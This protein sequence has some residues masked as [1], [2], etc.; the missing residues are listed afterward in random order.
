MVNT[1]VSS[2]SDLMRS[3]IRLFTF[4]ISFSSVVTICLPICEIIV[5]TGDLSMVSLFSS[6]RTWKLHLYLTN[7]WRKRNSSRS[8]SSDSLRGLYITAL[9]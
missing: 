1:S 8:C 5:L 4:S 7:V 2:S 9:S 3:A 6:L